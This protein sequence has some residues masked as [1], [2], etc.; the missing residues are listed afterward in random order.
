VGR[1]AV[2]VGSPEVYSSSR[3][4]SLFISRL[5][6]DYD[7][8][9]V[10]V[11]SPPEE[12]EEALWGFLRW[13]S[14]YGVDGLV[15]RLASHY[16]AM[17]RALVTGDRESEIVRGEIA[18]LSEE[19]RWL[20]WAIASS[21][22]YTWQQAALLL[23]YPAKLSAALTAAALRSQGVEALWLSGREA[24]LL[25]EGHPLSAMLNSDLVTG[26]VGEKLGGM[27]ERGVTI[28]LAGSVAGSAAAE[29]A[30]LLGWGGE[31][32]A[33]VAVAESLGLHSVDIF[34]SEK[35][36]GTVI[37]EG[38]V[39]GECP[40]RISVESLSLAAALRAL[41][42][43]APLPETRA[44][45]RLLGLAGCEAVV[46]RGGSHVTA[47]VRVKLYSQSRVG[48]EYCPLAGISIPGA[49]T[50]A[51]MPFEKALYCT[52]PRTGSPQAPATA[53][54]GPVSTLDSM[55]GLEKAF[56]LIRR[57]D[58]ALAVWQGEL[59]EVLRG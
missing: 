29:G 52:K 48:E 53:G 19:V 56:M 27:L 12:L 13:K 10:V 15:K 40:A 18:R 50:D 33:A 46:A 36:I 14:P 31:V 22:S 34:Y 42:L 9:L 58:L 49:E 5:V 28:V 23:T 21:R 3:L 51:G 39:E 43:P 35:G 47:F 32:R 2:V 59:G 55:V 20:L 4:L 6:E 1:R 7:E 45:L 41:R 57:R 38:R 16:T 25:A 26:T 44:E 54:V 37:V 11:A 24:G 8:G 30:K 17:A